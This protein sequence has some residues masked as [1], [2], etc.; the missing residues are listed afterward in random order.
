MAGPTN[1]ADVIPATPR[2]TQSRQCEHT[3]KPSYAR[4]LCYN[5]Y[6]KAMRMGILSE[7]PKRAN[8]KVA[9]KK[10]DQNAFYGEFPK[11]PLRLTREDVISQHGK[12]HRPD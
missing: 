8:R 7:F 2:G 1:G 5:C 3:E 10:R 6:R 11:M 4:G 12:A 9:R